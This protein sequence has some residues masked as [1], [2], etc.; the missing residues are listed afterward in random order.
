MLD[1][2]IFNQQFSFKNNKLKL[3]KGDVRD[4]KLMDKIIKDDFDY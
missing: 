3:I 4:I 1:N 2:F